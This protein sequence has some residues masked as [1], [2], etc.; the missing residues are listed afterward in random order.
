M[1]HGLRSFYRKFLHSCTKNFITV[2]NKFL[3]GNHTTEQADNPPLR[4]VT[5]MS[6]ACI[7]F[8]LLVLF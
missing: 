8:V 7:V 3:T 2:R 6:D 4:Y 5:V 1:T